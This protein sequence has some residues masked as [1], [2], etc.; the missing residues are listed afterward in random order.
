MQSVEDRDIEEYLKR[1]QEPQ[2]RHQE[3]E[4][5]NQSGN[6]HER[7]REE[8]LARKGKSRE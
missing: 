4:R 8:A 3:P 1:A 2:P 6:R 7:R 5:T